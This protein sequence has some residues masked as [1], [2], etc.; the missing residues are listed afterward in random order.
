MF[1]L[2]NPNTYWV[3]PGRFM[4]GEYPREASDE[5][6]R[7]KLAAY[8]RFGVSLFMDLTEEG[9]S[10][11]LPY[12]SILRDLAAEMEIDVNYERFPIPDTGV[13]G[14]RTMKRIL[15]RIDEALEEDV[16][17]YVHCRGGVGR[18]GTVVATYLV[19]HGHT[20]DEALGQLARWWSTVAKRT[21]HP[22][23]PENSRQEAFVRSW[24]QETSSKS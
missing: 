11:L 14:R 22:R 6:S 17:V 7:R 20:A 1:A 19:R 2:P 18:T 3:N 10:G 4:A 15:N 23:S 9:E 24:T 13:P 8:L 5:A 16:T 12:H 21:R